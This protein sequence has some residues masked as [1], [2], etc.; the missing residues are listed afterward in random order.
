MDWACF[1]VS[2]P[3]F[4][5]LGTSFV[6]FWVAVGLDLSLFRGSGPTCILGLYI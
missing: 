1:G 5:P 2:G 4:G 3:E 6:P